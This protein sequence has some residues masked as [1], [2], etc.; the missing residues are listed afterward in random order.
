MIIQ[1]IMQSS[2]ST[3]GMDFEYL[4]DYADNEVNNMPEPVIVVAQTAA[5]CIKVSLTANVANAVFI[6]IRMRKFGNYLR[7]NG[8]LTAYS[9]LLTFSVAL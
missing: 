9:T 4:P 2:A 8:N 5:A 1:L 3:Y 7:L 6:S